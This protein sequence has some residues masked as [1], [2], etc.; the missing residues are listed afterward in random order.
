[1]ANSGYIQTNTNF[2]YV[3]LDWSIANQNIANNTSTVNYALAI[4]R[5]TNINSSVSKS[6]SININGVTVASGT[7]TIGGAGLKTIK[8][9]TT[10]IAHNADGSKNFN[11]SFSQQIDITYSGSWV[12][13][14]TGSGS[15][16]LNT[17]ARATQL[18]LNVTA[19]D[20]G[21]VIVINLPRASSNFTH[22]LRYGFGSLRETI[23]TNVAT[24]YSWTL[25]MNLANQIGNAT[26]GVGLIWC[27]T[28]N[29]STLIGTKEVAFTVKVPEDIKPYFTSITATEAIEGLAAQFGA[30]IQH[31]SKVSITSNA[32]GVY[33]SQIVSYRHEILGTAYLSKDFTS[34]FLSTSGTITIVSYCTDTRGRVGTATT[35]INV[36][37]YEPPKINVFNATRSLSNG[38]ENYEGTYLKCGFNFA[39]TPLNNKN[40]KQ[41]QIQYKLKTAN[42][43]TTLINNT[44]IY[45]ANSTYTSTSAVLADNNSYDIRFIVTDYFTSITANVEVGTAFT[46]MDFRNTGRGLGIGKVS[47]KDKLEI[48]IPVEIDGQPIQGG[49]ITVYSLGQ[50]QLT[51]ANYTKVN[52]NNVLS[53]AGNNFILSDNNVVCNKTG[54]VEISGMVSITG[55]TTGDNFYIFLFKENVAGAGSSLNISSITKRDDWTTI[56]ATPIIVDVSKGDKIYISI[57]NNNARGTLSVGD[58]LAW[59]NKLTV[60]Y[61]G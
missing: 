38:A 13:T 6:Y 11:Y 19:Q 59:M 28:Y 48:G 4:Q 16:T 26:S 2:G 36:L 49:A 23:I 12:G 53:Q 10:T 21:K 61:V 18:T 7:T 3:R 56:Q 47:E 31:K 60:R 58:N 42:E 25:P 57:L 35:V 1:M 46:L 29:G 55:G 20:V 40:T 51:T 41:Y 50:Q 22:T 45:N 27:D 44:S 43:W 37:P 54:Y 17:I 15:G 34:S 39:V 9:G 52:F 5:N 8:S 30:Y 24:T 32:L 33:S 14:V